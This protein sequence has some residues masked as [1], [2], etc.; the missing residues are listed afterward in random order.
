MPLR[1]LYCTGNEGKWLE[2]LATFRHLA[3]DAALLTRCD[4]DPTELQA[5]ADDIARAKVGEAHRL[6]Q[7][8]GQLLAPGCAPAYDWL[9]A[10]DV[11]FC[12]DCLNGFPGPYVKDMLDAL[13]EAGL[14]DLVQRY[15]PEQRG[16]RAVCR[17]AAVDLRTGCTHLFTGELAGTCVLPRGDVRHGKRSWNGLFQPCGY[18]Q[19]FGEMGFEEQARMSHRHAALGAFWAHCQSREREDA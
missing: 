17:V 16:A 19:T 18:A 13:G 11:S 7:Q 1:V 12:L 15:A 6:L 8:P 2:A 4:A 5:P 14:S 9:L 3:G 10:E